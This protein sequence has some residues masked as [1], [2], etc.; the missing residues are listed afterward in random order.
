MPR[1]WNVFDVATRFNSADLG[2]V[3]ALS[4]GHFSLPTSTPCHCGRD[5]TSH[6][7]SQRHYRQ[8]VYQRQDFHTGFPGIV[9]SEDIHRVQPSLTQPQWRQT[10]TQQISVAKTMPAL[11]NQ[12]ARL[13]QSVER[14]TLEETPGISS[15]V[16]SSQGCGFDPHVGLNSR[17]NLA[18]LFLGLEEIFLGTPF[19]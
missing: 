19:C 6:Q 11:N 8:S 2:T 13:A 12:V 1:F 15:G 16:K 5:T 14:E 3:S 9:A 4:P 17:R 7:A 18:L 10:S